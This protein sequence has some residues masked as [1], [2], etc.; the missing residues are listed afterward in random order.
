MSNLFDNEV[1]KTIKTRRS[2]RSYLPNKVEEEKINKLLECAIL[3]PSANNGQPW[4]FTVVQDTELIN[5]M[6]EE[7]RQIMLNSNDENLQKRASQEDFNVFHGANTLI[8][9]AGM[10]S[11]G[12]SQVD[13]AA[14]TQNILLT[15]KSLGIATCWIGFVGLLFSSQ[16]AD[17]YVKL[18]KIPEGYKPFWAI[19]LG[20][21]DNYP[22]K[23]RERNW[24]VVE[25]IK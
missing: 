23:P 4:F 9:V 18:L 14:A 13:C 6:N 21:T 22:E 3:A 15:A 20:Y 19:T 5:K 8:I 10:E 1:I 7:I 24:N 25:W 11:R 17:E 2:V 12:S 16:K